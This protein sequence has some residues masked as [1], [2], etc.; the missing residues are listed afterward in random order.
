MPPKGLPKPEKPKRSKAIM[1]P[2]ERKCC[3][4]CAR[5]LAYTP[6]LKC[7][8]SAKS[9]KC[10]RCAGMHKKCITTIP[11][12]LNKPLD[13]LMARSASL[14]RFQ[15]SSETDFDDLKDITVLRAKQRAFNARLEKIVREQRRGAAVPRP[16]E[17]AILKSLEGIQAA[18]NGILDVCR[19]SLKYQNY[20]EPLVQDDD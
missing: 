2:V 9:S 1:T 7:S 12:I 17:T 16:T 11:S 4:R 20:L 14:A 8:R 18:L 3:M 19:M 13:E 10:T 5:Q 6:G 15:L